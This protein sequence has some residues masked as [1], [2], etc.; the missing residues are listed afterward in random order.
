MR[1]TLLLLLLSISLI[2]TSCVKKNTVNIDLSNEPLALEISE[3]IKLVQRNLNDSAISE[4]HRIDQGIDLENT[5]LKGLCHHSL[6]LAHYNNQDFQHALQE[7]TAA[8]HY[9]DEAKDSIRSSSSRLNASSCLKQLGVYDQAI[10]IAQEGITVLQKGT[11]H[12]NELLMGYNMLGNLHREIGS[13]QTSKEYHY[14][15]LALRKQQGS[16]TLLLPAINNLGNC[17]YSETQYDSAKTYFT[18]YLELS[19]E[20]NKD[21]K[22]GRAFENLAKTQLKLNSRAE[23]KELLDSSE[24]YHTK[25]NNKA[26]MVALSLIKADYYRDVT[27]SLSKQW[28]NEALK[29]SKILELP[30]EELEALEKLEQ[31][32]INERSFQE[33]VDLNQ[34]IE[35]LKDTLEG[36]EQISKAMTYEMMSRIERKRSEL[37]ALEKDKQELETVKVRNARQRDL[38]ILVCLLIGVILY[39]V[40]RQYEEGRKYAAEYFSSESGIILKSGA[41]VLFSEIEYIESQRNDVKIKTTKAEIIERKT[42]ISSIWEV[43]PKIEFGRLQQGY[44]V[45]YRYAVQKGKTKVE[46]GN[47]EIKISRKYSEKFLRDWEAFKEKISSKTEKI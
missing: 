5:K 45:G 2:F 11:L 15:S 40:Y 14:K 9:F 3:A 31:C 16:K 20:L 13:Y 36:K 25:V 1:S 44:I 21:G 23:V 32:A 7:Y 4:L 8:I 29:Q 42:T 28:A 27:P 34:Q 39:F 22:I 6:G 26:G 37:L 18:K 17:F 12:K 30:R 46:I 19:R 41:L 33:A 47:L 10:R 38:F 24:Y 43:L 35:T